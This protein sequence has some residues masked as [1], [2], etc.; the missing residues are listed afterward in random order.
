MVALAVARWGF[1]FLAGWCRCTLPAVTGGPLP[2]ASFVM[3]FVL[4]GRAGDYTT[5]GSRAR[6]WTRGVL[7]LHA[8]G[9]FHARVWC[10]CCLSLDPLR[11]LAGFCLSALSGLGDLR[12][13]LALESSPRWTCPMYASPWV[14]LSIEFSNNVCISG[15]WAGV[16]L[17]G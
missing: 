1:F 16:S 4:R 5:P 9:V 13:T 12:P 6:D 2:V 15:R 10:E 11:W 7:H 8:I 3:G 14:G 17:K